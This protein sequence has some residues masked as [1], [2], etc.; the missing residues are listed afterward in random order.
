MGVFI[1]G[2]VISENKKDGNK[3]YEMSAG[4]KSSGLV[5]LFTA[6][7][8]HSPEIYLTYPVS[9]PL[10]IRSA[11]TVPSLGKQI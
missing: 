2:A 4:G 11:T 8:S 3:D 7:K 10:E 9:V 5:K 6:Y 1:L